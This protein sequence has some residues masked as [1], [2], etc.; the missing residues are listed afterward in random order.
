LWEVLREA[1]CEPEWPEALEDCCCLLEVEEVL[2]DCWWCLLEDE[3][4]AERVGVR[5]CCEGRAD[6]CLVDCLVWVT[7]PDVPPCL[8]PP[9]VRRVEELEDDEDVFVDV[10]VLGL[11]V[12]AFISSVSKPMPFP[13]RNLYVRRTLSSPRTE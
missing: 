7:T 11:T 13:A 2:V 12:F 8:T 10:R 6:P 3:E 9:P 1:P 4:A 5:I